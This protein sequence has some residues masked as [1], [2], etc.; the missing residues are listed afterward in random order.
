MPVVTPPTSTLVPSGSDADEQPSVSVSAPVP[1]QCAAWPMYTVLPLRNTKFAVHCAPSVI[2]WTPGWMVALPTAA[3]L[4]AA[5]APG[6]AGRSVVA[7]NRAMR[8]KTARN[9]F[10]DKT[11]YPS[12]ARP[13]RRAGA[14]Q[15]RATPRRQAGTTGRGHGVLASEP[16]SSRMP[17]NSQRT[18]GTPIASKHRDD[19]SPRGVCSRN[20]RPRADA[21]R[22]A[23]PH[24][25]DDHRAVGRE[26]LGERAARLR[27]RTARS[28]S[29]RACASKRLMRSR[30]SAVNGRR[31][32]SCSRSSR[33]FSSSIVLRHP[34]RRRSSAARSSCSRL[35]STSLTK[36]SPIPDRHDD[37]VVVRGA[38]SFTISAR[39]L[40][41]MRRH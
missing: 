5:D 9:S 32:S 15:T 39:T 26:S 12:R 28:I 14:S 40:G 25:G 17:K 34:P 19:A 8:T 27:S 10:H 1:E 36:S 16:T 38:R 6:A 13:K 29:S 11:I 7:A 30:P 21:A 33:R 23:G 4:G 2:S 31:S 41:G 37:S 35:L 22:C 18:H 24:A 20:R 3:H